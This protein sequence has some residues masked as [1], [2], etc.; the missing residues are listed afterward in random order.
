[1]MLPYEIIFVIPFV[2]G[3]AWTIYQFVLYN[4]EMRAWINHRGHEFTVVEKD[5]LPYVVPMSQ[6]VEHRD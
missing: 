3:V 4:R 6:Q 5:D 2:V 1:M